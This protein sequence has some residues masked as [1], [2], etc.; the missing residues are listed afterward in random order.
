MKKETRITTAEGTI[1]TGVSDE[2]GKTMKVYTNA[3]ER[4]NIEILGTK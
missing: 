1:Y 4:M 2:N 3:P